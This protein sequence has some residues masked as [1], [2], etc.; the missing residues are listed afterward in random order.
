VARI[1]YLDSAR[2]ILALSVIILHSAAGY[3]QYPVS[4]WPRYS[5]KC[6]IAFDFLVCILE[7]FQMPVFFLLAGFCSYFL[8]QKVGWLCFMTNRIK[9]IVV[10]F[11]IVVLLINLP[12]L[13][14]KLLAHNIHTIRDGLSVL[15]N[16]SFVWFLEYLLILYLTFLFVVSINSYLKQIRP[17]LFRKYIDLYEKFCQLNSF[18][19]GSIFVS[20]HFTFLYFAGDWFTPVRLGVIPDIWV[21]LIYSLYFYFGLMIATQKTLTTYF[22]FSY[23]KLLLTGIIYLFYMFTMLY[24]HKNEATRC[25]AIAIYAAASY[26]L[27]YQFISIC[28][29]FFSNENKFLH[30]LSRASYCIYL[31]QVFFIM[32]VHSF[33]KNIE[34]IFIQFGLICV[35]TLMLSLICFSFYNTLTLPSPASEH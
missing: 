5:A 12:N 17:N 26:L 9:R 3:L 19:L 21:M 22:I 2:G 16:L 14:V 13:L 34:S 10:P 30:L 8:F 6:H 7:M 33:V 27:T 31:T 24:C 29:K 15:Q 28:I 1:T 23:K 4:V 18:I 25:F 11:C 32:F 20:L 35:L